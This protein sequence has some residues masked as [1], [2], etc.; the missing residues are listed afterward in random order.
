MACHYKIYNFVLHNKVRQLPLKGQLH[1][2]FWS[3]VFFM[4]TRTYEA[5]ITALKQFHVLHPILGAI[6]QLKISP[7]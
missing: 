4:E 2:I 6:Q 7:Q 1:E 5:L 3:G